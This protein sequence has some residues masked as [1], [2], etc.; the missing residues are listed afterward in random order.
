[1]AKLHMTWKRL[2]KLSERLYVDSGSSTPQ[3][4]QLLQSLE[5]L[6]TDTLELEWGSGENNLHPVLIRFKVLTEAHE[7]DA[8]TP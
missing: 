6:T 2:G 7:P 3:L 1:M 8:A 4:R 5:K